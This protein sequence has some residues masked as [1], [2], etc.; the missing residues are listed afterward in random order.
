MFSLVLFVMTTAAAAQADTLPING[1]F[2][3][4]EGKPQG[5]E[6]KTWGGAGTFSYDQNGRN[7]S[8]CVGIT[9]Q[10]GGDLSWFTRAPVKAYSRYRLSGYVK[11]ENVAPAGGKGALIN[12]HEGPAGVSDAITGTNDWTPVSFEF[13]SG[14][15][16]TVMINC[17]FG[18]WGHAT[19][20][21]WFDDVQLECLGATPLERSVAIDAA[22][23]GAPIS[24]YIYGQ[25]IEHLGRCIYGGIWAEMIEDRKFFYAVDSKE[26]PWKSTGSGAEMVAADAFVGEH[27]PHL[28][29]GGGIAQSGLGVVRG[30]RYD[31]HIVL[32]GSGKVTV[33]LIWGDGDYARDT[34]VVLIKS[35]SGP[36]GTSFNSYRLRFRAG[37][38]TDNA[39]IEITAAESVG[40]GTLSLMPADNV[41]GMRKDT[42]ALLKELD[43]PVY[44][45]PGGNFVSGY[46]WRDGIGERD[47]RP[48]RKNPAWLGIEHNDFGIHEFMLFCE[49]IETEPY[50]AVNSGLG[51]VD[52]ARD[53]VEYVNGGEDSPMGRLRAANGRSEPWRC[54]YW[55]IGNEMYGNWQLGHMP[56]ED[57]VRKHNQFADAMRAVDPAIQLIAVGDTGKWSEQMLANCAEHMELLSE[58]FYCQSKPGLIEHVKQIPDAVRRKAV[59]HRQYWDTIPSLAGKKVPIALD[60][61]N[62]WY[63][64]YEFGE[65]GTRYFLQDALGIAAGIHEI[66]RNSDVFFMANYAQ[67]VNVIGA[68]KTT[69]TAA[70]FETT[71][72]AL[73]LYRDH[74][75]TIP[76]AVTGN[77]DPLDVV[78]AWN[79][80]RTALTIGVVNP[81]YNEV[82]LNLEVVGV[83]RHASVRGWQISGKDPMAYNNPG[84]RL[85]VAIE[86]MRTNLT[87]N[88]HQL[89]I[90]GISASV[91]E[92]R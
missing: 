54:K 82:T 75:G 67:T 20:K 84:D 34:N 58:H 9:S 81:T 8:W 68:I 72:L 60:E 46:D 21:A 24:K 53:E 55:S 43:A 12:L 88:V 83:E 35:S 76:V 2:E 92:L 91:L 7:G 22:Q 38:S 4:P 48:P 23:M 50:I 5:W 41:Y 51:G 66:A 19:G 25:F 39:R 69:K 65:L 57:Y 30:K 78:A 71:G 14:R 33:N 26:S 77:T 70:A 17:L 42:L 1:S 27:T 29:A 18:G 63:G 49:E 44:R 90:P 10:H 89:T 86:E 32:S 74:F 85:N 16:E 87:P 13:E 11:T 6:K 61:W 28:P 79:E 56:L 3:M 47:K 15:F 37:A 31:G 64:P 45:W 36:S 52:G 73:K 40:I 59:A 80:T 62:Y